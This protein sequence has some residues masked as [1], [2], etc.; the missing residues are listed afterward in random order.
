M[1]VVATISETQIP[2]AET[3]RGNSKKEERD[4]KKNR[5]IGFVHEILL[6]ICQANKAVSYPIIRG[7]SKAKPK[8][9]KT[10]QLYCLKSSSGGETSRYIL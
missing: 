4:K 7:S 1:L 5:Y 3:G 9:V 8:A 10:W 6:A 2:K